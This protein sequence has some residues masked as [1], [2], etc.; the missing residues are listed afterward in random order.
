MQRSGH[1]NCCGITH[2]SSL[3]VNPEFSFEDTTCA[4]RLSNLLVNDNG[5][6]ATEIVVT[7]QQEILWRPV[8][9]EKGFQ[10]VYSFVNGNSGNEC[11]VYIKHR[12]L[13]VYDPDFESPP[14]PAAP[15]VN[16]NVVL[17]EYYASLR[18][19]GRRGPFDTVEAAREAYPRCLR[20]EVRDIFSDGAS[21][22][23][24]ID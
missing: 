21:V 11:N 7:T 5:N 12:V 6:T 20:F 15:V 8:L 22:W 13:R 14:L 2:I 19:V 16:M 24:D 10:K 1:I 9:L 3:G 18:T 4:Q 23:G 17:T